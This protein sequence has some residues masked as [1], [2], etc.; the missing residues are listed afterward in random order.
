MS[1][2]EMSWIETG[3]VVMRMVRGPRGSRRAAN[4]IRE[5]GAE[6]ADVEACE[7]LANASME[8]QRML[9]R[10]WEN[11]WEKTKAKAANE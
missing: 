1:D 2:A 9:V 8:L 4:L 6:L 10:S 3:G 5:I 11:R 7:D